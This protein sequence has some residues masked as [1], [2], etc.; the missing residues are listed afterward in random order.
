MIVE[1]LVNA[2]VSV[3]SSQSELC[4]GE[5]VSCTALPVNGGVPSYQWYLNGLPSGTNQPTFTY[6]P[7]NNDQVFVV[8][9]SSLPCVNGNPATSNTLE[10]QV[11]PYPEVPIVSASGNT[12]T[13]NAPSGNQ[14]Y[15]EGS[16]LIGATGQVYIAT[17]YGWYWSVVTLN[18]C[19][20]DSSNH[21]YVAGVGIG[22]LSRFADIDIYPVPNSGLFTI[23]VSNSKAGDYTLSIYNVLGQVIWT[24]GTFRISGD[25]MCHPDLRPVAVGIY[26]VVLSNGN[27][28]V[29]RKMVIS[30]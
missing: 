30:N 22:E 29:V 5:E 9:T 7:D 20:S 28:S 6:M 3:T 2:S 21:V 17:Q 4:E 23:K 24:N 11:Y 12:L 15:R 27:E 8:M 16:A 19:S 14:W 13:S 1:S 26:T 25:F 10:M 18:G